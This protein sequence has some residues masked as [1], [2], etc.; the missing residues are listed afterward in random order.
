MSETVGIE[1]MVRERA[2]Q[3]TR[4]K[5]IRAANTFVGD[6]LAAVDRSGHSMAAGVRNLEGQAP[7]D[8][9]RLDAAVN[10]IFNTIL[11]SVETSIGNNAVKAFVYTVDEL[12]KRAD[13]HK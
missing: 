12:A 3:A 5:L 9:L 2:I 1:A 11:K 13:D 4:E 6:V 10:R 8:E 7:T